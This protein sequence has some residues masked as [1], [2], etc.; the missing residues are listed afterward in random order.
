[1]TMPSD[2][3]KATADIVAL[4]ETELT[5]KYPEGDNVFWNAVCKTAGAAFENATLAQSMLAHLKKAL[6]PE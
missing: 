4:I 5:V 3:A 1:M 2:I 6:T